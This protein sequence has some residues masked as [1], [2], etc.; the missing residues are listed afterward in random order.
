MLFDIKISCLGLWHKNLLS[1]QLSF[2]KK[3]I[4]VIEDGGGGIVKK[5]PEKLIYSLN[6]ESINFPK[7]KKNISPFWKY[8][9]R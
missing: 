1:K 6:K 9:K 2:N 8:K 4:L 3:N 7:N 5:I